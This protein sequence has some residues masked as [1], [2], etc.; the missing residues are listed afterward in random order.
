M[1]ARKWLSASSVPVMRVP[2]LL[3]A[4]AYVGH[5]LQNKHGEHSLVFL[6]SRVLLGNLTVA[7][8]VNIFPAC[9]GIQLFMRTLIMASERDSVLG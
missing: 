6:C 4:L 2:R 1:A 8:L 5:S 9:N 3:W 7:Q